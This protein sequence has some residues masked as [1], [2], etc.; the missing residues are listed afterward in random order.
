MRSVDPMN[1][2]GYYLGVNPDTLPPTIRTLTFPSTI[3]ELTYVWGEL[4]VTDELIVEDELW[5]LDGDPVNETKIVT[6]DRTIGSGARE[7]AFG[8]LIVLKELKV[9]GELIILST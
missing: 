8:E 7:L 1:K 6:Y 2:S 4:D 9:D 3:K 5:V